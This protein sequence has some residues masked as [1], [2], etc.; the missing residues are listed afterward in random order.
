MQEDVAGE[1]PRPEPGELRVELEALEGDPRAFLVV[2]VGRTVDRRDLEPALDEEGEGVRAGIGPC[3][4]GPEVGHGLGRYAPRALGLAADPDGDHRFRTRGMRSV[5]RC[6]GGRD[7]FN[8]VEVGDP[9]RKG[10]PRLRAWAKISALAS[11]G[12]DLR[13]LATTGAS[14]RGVR[15]GAARAG[16]R[17]LRPGPSARCGEYPGTGGEASNPGDLWFAAGSAL[18]SAGHDLRSWERGHPRPRTYPR[19]TASDPPRCLTR[20]CQG[21]GASPAGTR[22]PARMP[23][24]PGEASPPAVRRLSYGGA[25]VMGAGLPI[26]DGPGRRGTGRGGDERCRTSMTVRFRATSSPAG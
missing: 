5:G 17:P 15:T 9:D 16:G 19:S 3:L 12:I 14:S 6:P 13:P 18:D 8:G 24:L 11:R 20:P 10:A 23:A 4:G 22:S 21:E 26:M 1:G 7:P 25:V 2:E